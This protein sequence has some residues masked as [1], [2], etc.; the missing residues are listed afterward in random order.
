MNIP[1]YNEAIKPSTETSFIEK[2]NTISSRH[3]VNGSLKKPWNRIRQLRRTNTCT[4]IK[5]KKK[6]KETKNK[7]QRCNSDFSAYKDIFLTGRNFSKEK[8]ANFFPR[9]NVK[10]AKNTTFKNSINLYEEFENS[11]NFLWNISQ[12]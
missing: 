12:R 8:P 6:K 5:K 7:C 4:I 3:N 10:N 1:T 9:K 2:K 11:K